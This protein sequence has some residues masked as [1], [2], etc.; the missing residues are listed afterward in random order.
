MTGLLDTN[1]VVRYLVGD[2]PDLAEQAA[3]IIDSPEKV[4]ITG[5]VLTE[6]AY[7]LLSVYGIPRDVVVD[8]LI[9]FLQ[10]ENVFPVSLD[11]SILLLA[12]LL[13]RHSGRI[14]FADAV[15]WADA[16]SNGYNVVY[17][18]DKKFPSDGIEVRQEI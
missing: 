1:I 12:L 3:R 7:V 6:T 11:K 16:R 18:L 15:V 4:G 5:V 9:A 17:S 14:S 8:H 10:K 13:C 2:S